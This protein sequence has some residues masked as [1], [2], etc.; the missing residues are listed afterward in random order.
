MININ[1][2]ELAW[3]AGFFDGEGGTWF[4]PRRDKTSFQIR[5]GVSQSN[6][7]EDAIPAELIRFQNAVQG[8]GTFYLQRKAKNVGG[9]VAWM[10]RIHNWQDVQFVGSLLY[11]FLS[12]TK[13]NQFIL[14]TKNFQASKSWGKR[15]MKI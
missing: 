9:R 1:R 6:N 14:A 15:R 13:Q 11:T 2:E 12:L 7:S 8:L 3:A 4:C 5:M 10:W